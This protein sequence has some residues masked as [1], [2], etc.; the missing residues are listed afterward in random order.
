MMS[1]PG[2]QAANA[3]RSLCAGHRHALQETKRARNCP[4]PCCPY[5]TSLERASWVVRPVQLGAAPSGV[6]SVER[7][8]APGKGVLQEHT[9]GVPDLNTDHN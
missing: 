6:L 9:A 8:R 4:C 3:K 2:L 5:F 1:A 7:V